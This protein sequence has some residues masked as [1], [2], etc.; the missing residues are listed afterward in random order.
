EPGSTIKPF[1]AGPA[2]AWRLTRVEEVFPLHGPK[3]VVTYGTHHRTITDV[4]G[5]DKLA[6]W[7]VL[8]KSSNIGMCM[9]GERLG[10]PRLFKAI[11]SFGFGKKTGVEL[12]GEDPGRVNPLKKW[13]P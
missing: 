5:Y 10:N 9:L 12:P 6:F 8:V 4:H 2:L 13:T 3:Y 7:D 1:I 11:S